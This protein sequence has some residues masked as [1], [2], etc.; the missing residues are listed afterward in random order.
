MFEDHPFHH[1]VEDDQVK[2][3]EFTSGAYEEV[4][5]FPDIEIGQYGL[6]IFAQYNDDTQVS[7]YCMEVMTDEALE[8]SHMNLRLDEA[9]TLLAEHI[10]V[11]Y[12]SGLTIMTGY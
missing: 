8:C 11:L 10:K 1:H 5:G 3:P 7:V 6:T 4:E 2:T 12:K 9:F